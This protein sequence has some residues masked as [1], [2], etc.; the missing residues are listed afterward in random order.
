MIVG[1]QQSVGPPITLR[2]FALCGL[3][4]SSL[5]S[6]ETSP[7]RPVVELC[8]MASASKVNGALIVDAATEKN[9]LD[10]TKSWVREITDAAQMDPELI[11]VAGD[12]SRYAVAGVQWSEALK[13]YVIRIHAPDLDYLK[14]SYMADW[15]AKGAIAHELG[16]IYEFIRSDTKSI[17]GNRKEWELS[18]DQF[19]GRIL[20]RLGCPFEALQYA[21]H[22]YNV[23]NEEYPSTAARIAMMTRGWRSEAAVHPMPPPTKVTM[24]ESIWLTASCQIT[25]A[26]KSPNRQWPRELIVNGRI[27]LVDRSGRPMLE[28]GTTSNAGW[29]EFPMR[30]QLKNYSSRTDWKPELGGNSFDI[31]KPRSEMEY[32]AEIAATD[33]KKA[34]APGARLPPEHF[35]ATGDLA[36]FGS[37]SIWLQETDKSGQ[38]SMVGTKAEGNLMLTLQLPNEPKEVNKRP[39]LIRQ[40]NYVRTWEVHKVGD[41]YVFSF[42]NFL[43]SPDFRAAVGF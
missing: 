39:V 4:A 28:A 14:A 21:L 33:L 41:G 27:S 43:A 34:A 35:F 42:S 9:A 40:E 12:L 3:F 25:C 18:A 16:H 23:E 29:M 22:C 24:A 37:I 36:E 6:A 20:K 31:G 19:A 26:V 17:P 10:A 38:F 32:V 11:A 1:I 8:G 5:F 2:T 30:C 13:K 7:K 15:P